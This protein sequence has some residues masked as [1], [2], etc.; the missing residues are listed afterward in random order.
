MTDE[1]PKGV[2]GGEVDTV[3]APKPPEGYAE[4]YQF[5]YPKL[6]LFVSASALLIVSV[7]VYGWLL[8]QL[9]GLEVLPVVFEV[10]AGDE[11]AIVFDLGKTAVPFLFGFLGVAIVHELLHGVVYQRYGYEVSY[12]VYWRMGAVY[13]A[14]FHQFHSREHNLRVGIAPLAILTVVCLPLLAVP[15]PVIATTAFVILVLNTAGG[16]GDLYALW[17]FHRLPRG[18]VFYDVNIEHMYVFEPK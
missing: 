4:P 7:I 1:S 17:R 14:V 8:V 6:L 13:A 9:Q 18:T 16:A 15:N 12:G 11:V 3:S 5:E 2:M 10:G